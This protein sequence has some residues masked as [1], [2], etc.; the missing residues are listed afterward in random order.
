MT[1]V[2]CRDFEK[3]VLLFYFVL[4]GLR[5]VCGI[6]TTKNHAPNIILGNEINWEWGGVGQ[7]GE[8]F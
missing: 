7:N 5:L 2:F 3:F 6:P 8:I 4:T 1:E